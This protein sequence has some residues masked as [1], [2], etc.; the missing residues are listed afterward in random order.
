MDVVFSC[1]M[2]LESYFPVP[3]YLKQLTNAAPRLKPGTWSIHFNTQLYHWLVSGEWGVGWG[4]E[5]C[6]C[7][8]QENNRCIH[9]PPRKLGCLAIVD[10]ISPQGI[11]LMYHPTH[12]RGMA[13]FRPLLSLAGVVT[14]FAQVPSSSLYIHCL[15][16]TFYKPKSKASAHNAGDPG[17]IPESG[18]SPGEG[19]S[20]PL[21]YSCLENP[22]D[23]GAW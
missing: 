3:N 5:D 8:Y 7:A 12:Q 11:W 17:S 6:F 16:K 4:W 23:G 14:S 22:M 10:G 18:R 21:H 1:W 2:P 19:K 15:Q 13:L 20:N 9:W